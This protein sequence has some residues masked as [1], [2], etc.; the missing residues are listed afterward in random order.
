M[1]IVAILWLELAQFL[2]SRVAHVAFM[3]LFVIRDKGILRE[4]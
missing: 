4:D 1:K 3:Q 2:C